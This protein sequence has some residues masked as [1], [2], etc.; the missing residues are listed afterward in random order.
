M[1][2]GSDNTLLAL[3]G[4]YIVFIFL[5]ILSSVVSLGVA[6]ALM[7]KPLDRQGTGFALG[8]LLGPIGLIIA[9]TIRQNE[10]LE[11][12]EYVERHRVAAPAASPPEQHGAKPSWAPDEPPRRFS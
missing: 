7:L 8:F 6:G 9:W 4:A 10:L 11:R 5:A 12:A 3:F 1:N 2:F